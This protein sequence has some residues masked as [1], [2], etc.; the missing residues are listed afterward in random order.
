[1]NIIRT[2]RLPSKVIHMGASRQ[3]P[4]LRATEQSI[5]VK[6]RLLARTSG[7]CFNVFFSFHIKILYENSVN[8]PLSSKRSVNNH[9]M[10]IRNAMKICVHYDTSVHYL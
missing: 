10:Y 9:V 8:I 6:G 4:I 7:V 2:L 5:L 3:T 1:M